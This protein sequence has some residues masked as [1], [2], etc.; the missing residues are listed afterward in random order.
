MRIRSSSSSGAKL[1]S[2][3]KATVD[4]GRG[5]KL[6]MEGSEAGAVT[7]D[8]E[9]VAGVGEIRGARCDTSILSS[10]A[11]SVFS[12]SPSGLTGDPDGRLAATKA[13][14]SAMPPRLTPYLRVSCL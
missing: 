14:Q 2:R 11:A 12:P 9:E 6:E 4:G 5:G 8:V 13:F 7:R 10:S 1:L 3:S